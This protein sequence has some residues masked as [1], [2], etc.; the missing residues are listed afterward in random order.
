MKGL[1][2]FS[3]Q[4]YLSTVLTYGFADIDTT[5]VCT[6]V[7]LALYVHDCVSQQKAGRQLASDTMHAQHRIYSAALY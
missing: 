1:T 3:H 6:G 5:F 4:N 2:S 7:H